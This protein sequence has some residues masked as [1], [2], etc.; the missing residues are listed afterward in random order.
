MRLADVVVHTSVA[1]E[2][3]GRVVVEGM[4]AGRPVVATR[5]GGVD[6]IVEDGVTGV[7]VEPGDPRLLAAAV[8][9]LL[10]DPGRRRALA[11]R[12]HRHALQRF[13]LRATTAAIRQCLIDLQRRA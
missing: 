13:D 3:F 11:D 9:G 12:G 4:L 2:P 8:H 10:A 6:E 5:G 1:P 7:L